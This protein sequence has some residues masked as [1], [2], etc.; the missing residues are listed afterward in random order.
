[1]VVKQTDPQWWPVSIT[2]EDR[3]ASVPDDAVDQVVT[4]CMEAVIQQGAILTN[5][6]I[7]P[8]TRALEDVSSVERM[9]TAFRVL[10]SSTSMTQ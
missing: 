2:Q 1:M 5:E 6:H 7:M 3:S 4:Q 8:R 9:Q 10:N